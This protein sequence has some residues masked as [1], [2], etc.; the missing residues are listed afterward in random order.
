MS[1]TEGLHL[2]TVAMLQGSSHLRVQSSAEFQVAAGAKFNLMYER[3][4]GKTGNISNRG[5]SVI[6]STADCSLDIARPEAGAWKRLIFQCKKATSC[7][8]EI[9]PTSKGIKFGV[10]STET[11]VTCSSFA[12]K[13][14]VGAHLDL[15]GYDTGHWMIMGRSTTDA[16]VFTFTSDTG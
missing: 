4:T 9:R 11:K 16:V 15:L 14:K 1:S 6:L 10:G 13:H 7:I 2:K 5:V 3:C 8:Q 12:D